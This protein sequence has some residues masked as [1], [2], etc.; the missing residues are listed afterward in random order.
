M[1][2]PGTNLAKKSTFH[3][4]T[5]V[6]KQLQYICLVMTFILPLFLWHIHMCVYTYLE[7]ALSG[8]LRKKKHTQVHQ[9]QLKR[10]HEENAV[11]HNQQV[12]V[13]VLNPLAANV[14]SCWHYLACLLYTFIQDW[15]PNTWGKKVLFLS[16][17]DRFRISIWGFVT[18]LNDSSYSHRQVLYNTVYP[19][20]C[21]SHSVLG[22][23]ADCHRP[24]F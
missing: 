19:L 6:Q 9:L 23:A 15:K 17:S 8:W 13:Y 21:H 2:N 24:L 12:K 16:Y 20:M 18:N 10:R 11:I 1:S 7:V 4:T 5:K 14:E 22:K 3:A